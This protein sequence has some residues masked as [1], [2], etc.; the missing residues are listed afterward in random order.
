MQAALPSEVASSAAFR[1]ETGA[2]AVLEQSRF[3]SVIVDRSAMMMFDYLF[4]GINLR[5]S[6]YY[7]TPYTW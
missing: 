4:D 5:S 3:P 6:S 1:I 7:K 2:A